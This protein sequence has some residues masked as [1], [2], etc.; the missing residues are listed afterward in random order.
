MVVVCSIEWSDPKRVSI[1]YRVG[2]KS[3]DTH[4]KDKKKARS[5]LKQTS[6][7]KSKN[8]KRGDKRERD[9][10]FI[11]PERIYTRWSPGVDP[12]RRYR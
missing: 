12:R 7:E 8:T 10:L 6:K 9:R 2:T 11:D 3:R 4:H 1:L 5:R